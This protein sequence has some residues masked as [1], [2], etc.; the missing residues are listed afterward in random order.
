MSNVKKDKI[1][2]FRM[3]ILSAAG[4][5][6]ELGYA[7]EGAYAIPIILAAGIPLKYSSLVLSIS[8]IIGIIIQSFVGSASDQCQC[9]LGKRRPFILL[10]GLMSVFCCATLPYYFYYKY[11][12]SKYIVQCLLS[13]V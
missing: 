13:L 7:A 6:S 11:Q 3:L 12:Y 8:P 9:R 10:F 1:S 5:V 2:R 4:T